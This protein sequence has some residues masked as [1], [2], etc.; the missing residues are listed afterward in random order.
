MLGTVQSETGPE[1]NIR[2]SM[3]SS[4]GFRGRG[5]GHYWSRVGTMLRVP[6]ESVLWGKA[7]GGQEVWRWGGGRQWDRQIAPCFLPSPQPWAPTPPSVFLAAPSASGSQV[8]PPCSISVSQQPWI[9]DLRWGQSQRYSSCLPSSLLVCYP[10]TR[11][12]SSLC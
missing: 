9:P 12:F 4:I 3:T 8:H 1:P 10:K 11:S 2:Q 7:L 5:K 6:M